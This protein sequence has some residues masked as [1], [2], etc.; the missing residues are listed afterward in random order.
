M[1]TFKDVIFVI[2]FLALAMC[3]LFLLASLGILAPSP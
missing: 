3:V 1:N 2:A